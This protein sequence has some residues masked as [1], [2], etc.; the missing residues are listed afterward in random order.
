MSELEDNRL[1]DYLY[2]EMD[3]S[4]RQAFQEDMETDQ[5]LAKTVEDM[6]SMLGSLR[7]LD[8][9]EAP[10]DHLDSLILAQ[11]KQASES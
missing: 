7:T 4:E 3:P 1:V 10:S 5:A 8:T 11:A 2:G 6:Q 9:E